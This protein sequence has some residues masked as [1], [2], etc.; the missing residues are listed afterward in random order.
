[1]YKITI[2]KKDGS[3]IEDTERMGLK[4]IITKLFSLLYDNKFSDDNFATLTIEKIG[5]K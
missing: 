2:R 5:D 3:V 4:F 1:M